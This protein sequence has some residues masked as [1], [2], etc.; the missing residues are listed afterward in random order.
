MLFKCLE[1]GMPCRDKR[2]YVTTYFVLFF[3]F[4]FVLKLK[5]FMNSEP[6]NIPPYVITTRTNTL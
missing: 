4:H 5:F 2:G 1:L 3:S 6:L